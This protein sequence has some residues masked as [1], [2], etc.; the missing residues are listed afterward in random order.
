MYDE[1]VLAQRQCAE[2]DPLV[3]LDGRAVECGGDFR[4]ACY[5]VEGVRSRSARSAQFL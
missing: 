4:G 2:V 1:C 5:P 3:V